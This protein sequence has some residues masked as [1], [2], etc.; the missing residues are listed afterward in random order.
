MALPDSQRARL[1]KLCG[2]LA[3]DHEGERANAAAQAS[4]IINESGTT[5]RDVVDAAFRAP[6][7]VVVSR[8]PAVRRRQK[9]RALF[10]GHAEAVEWTLACGAALSD[11]EREF[12]NSIRG[13]D[14]L[15]PRQQRT[16]TRLLAN[17]MRRAA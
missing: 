13:V 5:W 7:P 17:V 1:A 16:L 8:Q 6:V 11:E 9:G 12:L 2:L 10:D 4:R 3:S 15:C 14:T